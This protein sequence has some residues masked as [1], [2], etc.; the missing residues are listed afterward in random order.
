[1]LGYALFSR[2]NVH[3]EGVRSG[4]IASVLVLPRVAETAWPRHDWRCS[5]AGCGMLTLAIGLQ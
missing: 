2:F 1:M 5:I 4:C 3:Q